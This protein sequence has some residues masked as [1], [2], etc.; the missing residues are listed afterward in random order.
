MKII[1]KWICSSLLFIFASLALAE[2]H[3]APEKQ[4]KVS[5]IK[6]GFH[7]LQGK[8]G[9]IL[10]SEGDDGL[11]IVDADYQDMS[12]ALEKALGSFDKKL[13]YVLNTHWHGD[14]TQGNKALGHHAT[15]VAHDNV[16]KRLSTRQEVKLFN[17]VSE[18]Y[19]KHALP[20]VTYEKAMTLY[21]NNHAIRLIHLPAGHTDGDTVV[22]FEGENL[23]H[24]G[25][26]FF[27]GFFPF[28]DVDA[29]GNVRG[30]ANNI[31]SLL[32]AIND[33]TVIVPGHGPIANKK[34]LI[35][36]RDMLLGTAREIEEKMKTKSMVEIQ[37]EG[38]SEKWKPWT[39]G[40][41]AEAKWIKIVHDSLSKYSK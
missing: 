31:T 10:L 1:N 5:E 30:M 2:S 37:Q 14:H 4:F 28:V 34:D 41:L 21:F 38:L 12:P 27:N 36:F 17:M 3:H 16:H 35:A 24:M 11:L 26:H 6:P 15:I 32:D 18:P 23:I 9:N 19:P 25:D 7:F 20:D 29:G 33:N 8:G 40:F 22:F 13:K 39:K